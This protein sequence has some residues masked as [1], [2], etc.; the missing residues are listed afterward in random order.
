MAFFG[1]YAVARTGQP[2]DELTAV[3]RVLDAGVDGISAGTLEGRWSDGDWQL[4][5]IYQ[6]WGLDAN[7]LVAE[8][9]AP[10]LIVYVIES[11]VGVVEAA[12]VDGGSW[13]ACLNPDDAIRAFD[14]ETDDAGTVAGTTELA[15]AWAAAAGRTPNPETIATAVKQYVGPS[16][17]G[18]SAFLIGLGFQF[19]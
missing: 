7:D 18:V 5:V 13:R 12:T 10:A 15:T 17:D 19:Q 6:G 2:I 14:F 9:G 16:G 11:A 3:R 4:V 1:Y 8:T